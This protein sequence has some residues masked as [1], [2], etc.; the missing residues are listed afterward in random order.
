LSGKRAS[1]LL[2]GSGGKRGAKSTK[3]RKK[4]PKHQREGSHE[5][6]SQR[7]EGATGS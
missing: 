1:T 2:G 4:K 3:S 7:A 6:S 5:G